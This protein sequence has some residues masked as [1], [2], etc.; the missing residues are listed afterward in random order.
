MEEA[1][2]DVDG[3]E[4]AWHSCG[5]G[6]S[7]QREQLRQRPSGRYLQGTFGGLE[8]KGRSGRCAA[9]S[10]QA[11]RAAARSPDG[12]SYV[13]NKTS[14]PTLHLLLQHSTGLLPGRCCPQP[15]ISLEQAVGPLRVSSR[16][17]LFMYLLC[18]RHCARCFTSSGFTAVLG[19]GPF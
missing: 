5:G 8:C 4:F 9:H 7:R 19:V 16:E 17:L 6:Y 2:V 10:S 13:L 1:A 11:A 15:H 3:E 12:L 18:A 14:S